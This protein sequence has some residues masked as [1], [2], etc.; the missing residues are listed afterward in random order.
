MSVAHL[1]PNIV[2]KILIEDEVVEIMWNEDAQVFAIS[3]HPE[4]TEIATFLGGLKLWKGDTNLS[5]TET[6]AAGRRV[7]M[8][9]WTLTG[10]P[11][12][13]SFVMIALDTIFLLS[14][15][16]TCFKKDLVY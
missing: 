1:L 13:D 9:G 16:D 5:P 12:D 3:P 10:T 6:M 8:I 15:Y 2:K 4:I 14:R 7:Q 11:V